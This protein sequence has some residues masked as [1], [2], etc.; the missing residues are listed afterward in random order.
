MDFFDTVTQQKIFAIISKYAG[1]SQSVEDFNEHIMPLIPTMLMNLDTSLIA[2]G[3]TK[4]LEDS[5]KILEAI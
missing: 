3:D 1:A 2:Y 5:C 4:K